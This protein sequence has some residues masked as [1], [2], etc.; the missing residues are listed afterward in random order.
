[1]KALILSAMGRMSEANDQIKK[2]L[3]KNM[4]N[5]TCWHVFGIINRKEK[6]YD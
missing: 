1:M 5:F 4:T 2:T 3:F 6:D